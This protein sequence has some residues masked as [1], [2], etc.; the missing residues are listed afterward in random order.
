MILNFKLESLFFY[1]NSFNYGGHPN[2]ANLSFKSI[3]IISE[4]DIQ[5]DGWFVFSQNQLSRGT[6]IHFHGNSCNITNHWAFI[7][8][9]PSLGFD[10]LTFDYR[11]YG[12]SDGTPSF[13][14]VFNDC[15]A[16][17]KFARQN[18]LVSN[19]SFIFL[20]QSLGGAFLI[21]AIAENLDK[22]I[23]GIILDSSFASF[24][25]MALSKF[26]LVPQ[27]LGRELLNKY[28]ITNE[29]DPE[30]FIDKL[31]INKIFIHSKKDIVVPYNL[32]ERLYQ[33]APEPKQFLKLDSANHLALFLKRKGKAWESIIHFLNFLAPLTHP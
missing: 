5:L 18:S 27:T 25:E 14:G 11:G 28:G 2:N 9:I 8:W 6:I 26:P 23:L 30:N 1:P 21:R 32:G 10:L 12:K 16:V 17:I 31:K 20:G 4:N 15:C 24:S 19:R 7:D 33:L 13:K 22:D 29:F 3:K